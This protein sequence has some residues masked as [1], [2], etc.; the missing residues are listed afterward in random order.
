[1]HK[2]PAEEANR[3]PIAGNRNKPG[4]THHI[5][6]HNW[7]LLAAL[8]LLTTV[9]LSTAL[10][11]SLRLRA[12]YIWPWLNT[13]LILVIALSLAV[14]ST[15]AYL[16]QQQRQVLRKLNLMDPS[17]CEAF[18]HSL[19]SNPRLKTL[20]NLSIMMAIESDLETILDFMANTCIEIFTCER[21]TVM[22]FEQDT[23][24]LMVRS[25][26]GRVNDDM[27]G[28][29]QKLG[30][31]IA[32]WAAAHRQALLLGTC[33]ESQQYP[34]LELK[35]PSITS[36]MVVPIVHDDRLLGVLNLT[37]MSTASKFTSEDLQGLQLFVEKMAVYISRAEQIHRMRATVK[38][39]QTT[40][41]K[42]DAKKPA[43][44]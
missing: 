28:T 30:E 43:N 22:T 15:I 9:G 18:T 27:I 41:C 33:Y 16:S 35:N 11:P 13:E 10:V 8:F 2:H 7:F 14:I 42:L 3:D 1:M 31:G 6:W 37:A 21:A 34:G 19:R 24:E 17:D 38:K 5:Y 12:T 29:R 26:S 40:R 39:L 23:G 36:A 20:S 25:I 32:G 4:K 44:L